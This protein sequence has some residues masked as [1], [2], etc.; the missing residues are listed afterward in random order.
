M[1]KATTCHTSNIKSLEKIKFFTLI[2]HTI[3]STKFIFYKIIM[4]VFFY[5]STNK[6]DLIQL[7][8]VNPKVKKDYFSKK[9]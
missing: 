2:F 8:E 1:T 9:H 6:N 4:L 7:K 3:I 5:V